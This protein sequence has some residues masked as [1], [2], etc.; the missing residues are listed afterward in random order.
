MTFVA[1]KEMFWNEQ[2]L[3][4]QVA[5]PNALVQYLPLQVAGT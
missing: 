3:P 1:D 2:Y 4:E 5:A